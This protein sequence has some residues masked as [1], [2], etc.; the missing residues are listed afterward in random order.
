LAAAVIATALAWIDLPARAEDAVVVSSSVAGL[1]PGAVL[2]EDRLLSLPEGDSAVLLF[3]SG[4]MLRLSGPYEGKPGTML[5]QD[6]RSVAALVTVLRGQRVNASVVGATRAIPG[7]APRRL[8][9]GDEVAVALERPGV[10]CVT[11]GD[12]VWLTRPSE[13]FAPTRIR[14]K[15]TT[16]DLV[17][18]AGSTR[19]EWPSDVPI[20]DGD[21]YEVLGPDGAQVA[22][23]TFRRAFA[24]DRAG[25][26]EKMLLGCQEQAV[27][28]LLELAA[29]L[30]DAQR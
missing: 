18:P 3:R 24:T 2:V 15:N 30:D 14:N 1:A 5:R 20:E 17:W 9:P 4:E 26:A 25:I 11:P 10:Y 21:A 23:M 16:R 29:S 6:D 7:R 13:T 27:P 12:A 28:A 19:I 8:V 22:S